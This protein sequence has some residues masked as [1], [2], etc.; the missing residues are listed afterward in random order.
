[1]QRV[2]HRDTRG[3]EQE[4]RKTLDTLPDELNDYY[5]IIIERIPSGIRWDNTYVVLEALCRSEQDIDAETLL[6]ILQCSYSS[7]I[8]DAE[9]RMMQ[10][11][12]L[13][14]HGPRLEW[15]ERYIKVV[16]GGL[17][18]V[19]GLGDGG[20]PVLQFMHQTVKEFVESPRFR[21]QLLGKHTGRFVRE[22]GHSFIAK[23]LFFQLPRKRTPTINELFFYHARESETTMDFSQYYFFATAPSFFPILRVEFPHT[24]PSLVEKAV[25]AGRVSCD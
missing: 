8:T 1:M 18:E 10:N 5:Q 24:L 13:P 25:F 3:L 2:Q 6:A 14:L 20:R 22:N 16:S 4:I 23:H 7:N 21:L 17:V 12:R 19:S 15:G 11:T 9:S